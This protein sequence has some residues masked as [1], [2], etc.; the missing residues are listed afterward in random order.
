MGVCACTEDKHSCVRG[1]SCWNANFLPSRI[2]NVPDNGGPDNRGFIVHILRFSH[3]CFILGSHDL[4]LHTWRPAGRG[5]V[6]QLRRYFVGGAQQ[7]N[8]LSYV[9]CPR[10]LQV[11]SHLRYLAPRTRTHTH[12]QGDRLSRYGFQTESS[13]SVRVHLYIMQQS[14]Y[15]CCGIDYLYWWTYCKK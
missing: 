15:S 3:R 1:N 10:D 7:I 4:T 11:T 9:A 2:I 14:R 5:V 6:D 12:A 8:D 13:G